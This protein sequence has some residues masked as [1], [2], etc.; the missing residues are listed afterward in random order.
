[1]FMC[2]KFVYY[3]TSNRSLRFSWYIRLSD[4]AN[5]ILNIFFE[6]LNE[7][8]LLMF[9]NAGDYTGYHN[10]TDLQQSAVRLPIYRS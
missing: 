6:R 2:I 10:H 5:E 3:R 7:I 1:M 8:N 9:N 4:S